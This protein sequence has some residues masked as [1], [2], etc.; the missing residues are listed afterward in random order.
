[1]TSVPMN[2]LNFANT[3]NP[4]VVGINRHTGSP[5]ARPAKS[6]ARPPSP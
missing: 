4:A 2:P 3:A 6:R 1:M 5:F